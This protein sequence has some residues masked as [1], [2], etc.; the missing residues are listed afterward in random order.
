MSKPSTSGRAARIARAALSAA[1]NDCSYVPY[2]CI[3]V[4]GCRAICGYVAN[5]SIS[6]RKSTWQ[7]LIVC[8]R[9]REQGR[10]KGAK[11]GS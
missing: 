5:V 10:G 7:V 8:Q 1:S 2:V 4:K 11:N 6:C 3:Q 9:T